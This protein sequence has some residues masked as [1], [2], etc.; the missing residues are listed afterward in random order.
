MVSESLTGEMDNKNPFLKCCSQN[1]LPTN[2][3][4]NM[5]GLTSACAI[6]IYSVV[7]L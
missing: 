3:L 7:P 1:I 2:V 6:L 4:A 5:E